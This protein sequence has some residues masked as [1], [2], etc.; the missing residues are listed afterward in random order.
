MSQEGSM[1]AQDLEPVRDLRRGRVLAA[2]A[3]ALAV[4]AIQWVL[5][6]LVMGG[7]A[8]PINDALD[9]F[10]AA[11]MIWLV[12]WHWLFLPAFIAELMPFVDLVPTWSLAVWIATRGPKKPKQFTAG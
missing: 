1:P 9:V 4:D 11:L 2:R 10:V 5:L 8:S 12:G 6:P 7:A 3:I